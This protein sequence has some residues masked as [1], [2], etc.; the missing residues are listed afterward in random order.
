LEGRRF[1]GAAGGWREIQEREKRPLECWGLA[2]AIR[3]AVLAMTGI[4]VDYFGHPRIADWL[5]HLRR[6]T[7]VKP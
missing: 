4:I 6:R 3:F 7:I 2:V 5:I 1:D